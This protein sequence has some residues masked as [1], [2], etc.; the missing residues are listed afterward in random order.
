M[1]KMFNV[2]GD[3]SSQQSSEVQY[4]SG[5]LKNTKHLEKTRKWEYGVIGSARQ[6]SADITS[7]P[8]E[9]IK[10]LEELKVTSK[11]HPEPRYPQWSEAIWRRIDPRRDLIPKVTQSD[12]ITKKFIED[13]DWIEKDLQD[14]MYP[15]ASELGQ[16]YLQGIKLLIS[17]A[18]N[19]CDKGYRKPND[20]NDDKPDE[21]S[22]EEIKRELI[23]YGEMGNTFELWKKFIKGEGTQPPLAKTLALVREQANRQVETID[24]R[25]ERRD[26]P[27]A[28]YEIPTVQQFAEENAIRSA[29]ENLNKLRPRLDEARSATES[30]GLSSVKEY[31][32]L[33]MLYGSYHKNSVEQI[34]Y[35]PEQKMMERIEEYINHQV[36]RGEE[37]SSQQTSWLSHI[38]RNDIF[39]KKF[40]YAVFHPFHNV[41]ENITLPAIY[42]KMT[43]NVG[44]FVP[45]QKRDSVELG[46]K[47]KILPLDLAT[48]EHH[49]DDENNAVLN[50]TVEGHVFHSGCV[51]RLPVLRGK[52]PGILT[53]AYGYAPHGFH[54]AEKVILDDL[55]GMCNRALE[56]AI[57]KDQKVLR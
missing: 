22:P 8:P 51:V 56:K 3:I 36:T 9:S 29:L 32:E 52:K 46:S 49:F 18:I 43:T 44:F 7:P 10:E 21:R 12:E 30:G 41:G 57:L 16:E 19:Q 47:T 15:I 24:A 20:V 13:A 26:N 40:C 4:E 42:K 17:S 1:F 33:A 54:R 31:S 53:L 50:K 37:L 6:Y 11:S 28:F 39:Q 2:K 35:I 34:S 55:W 38:F 14:S 45:G 5:R 25:L 27:I 23:L 48:V